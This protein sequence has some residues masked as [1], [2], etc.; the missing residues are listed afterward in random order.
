MKES[1]RHQTIQ[2]LQRLTSELTAWKK[3]RID[4]DTS[5]LGNYRGRYDSQLNHIEREISEA[6]KAVGGLLGGDLGGKTY[7]EVC[8]EFNF[9]DQRII[10]IR[11]VWDY[12]RERLDQRDD[13]AL[14][15]T[16]EAAD[17]V[18]WSCYHPYFQD[19]NRPAPPPPITGISYDYTASA[20]KTQSGHVL[21]RRID[22]LEGPMKEYF[23]NL[24]VGV[25]RL[26]PT[27]VT[28]P[29][30]LGLIAHECGHFLQDA[31]EAG[32]PSSGR[33]A[34]KVEA[35]VRRAGGAEADVKAWRR[36]SIEI[37][38]DW[39]AVLAL[40]PWS[41]WLLAP[42]VLTGQSGML[43]RQAAYPSPLVR[44]LLIGQI[45]KGPYGTEQLLRDLG[46]FE[47]AAVTAESQ[48]D[49]TVAKAVSGLVEQ[50]LGDSTERLADHFDYRKGDYA[51]GGDV[52]QW[53]ESLL[54]RKP[55]SPVSGLRAA[56]LVAAGA[57]RA[58]HELATTLDEKAL[59]PALAALKKRTEETLAK[60]H[61]EGKR[62]AL[63][64]FGE[65]PIGGLAQ[66]L[67]HAR[68]EEL[69]I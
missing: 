54:G 4:A 20:L 35:A 42:W 3:K 59:D 30:T 39:M 40:G 31:V 6:A 29:W 10:W 24:P 49:W 18:L 19:R 65:S 2:E 64:S 53:A 25:L 23:Q 14:K 36:W 7:G 9:H 66:A 15:P 57:L 43:S 67:L 45:A 37:F 68:E 13:N 26:P 34:D 61:E 63:P 50:P 58:H 16:L 12:F 17:E 44:L 21:E 33:F 5:D 48:L 51:L 69:M 46:V 27:V 47:Q 38:A 41:V 60:C 8:R 22:T 32:A 56:R 28:A 62:L 11:Y 1:R 52:E 55:R